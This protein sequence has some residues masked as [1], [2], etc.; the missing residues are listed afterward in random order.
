[1]PVLQRSNSILGEWSGVQDTLMHTC[2][3]TWTET[4]AKV[5]S[6]SGLSLN[7]MFM[8]TDPLQLL[9]RAIIELNFMC[10]LPDLIET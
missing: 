1:M 4:R 5:L 10:N 7:Q 6:S 8:E 2:A 9:G 3:D